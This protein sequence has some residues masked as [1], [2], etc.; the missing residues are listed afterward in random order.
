L[1]LGPALIELSKEFIYPFALIHLVFAFLLL[2]GYS[3]ADQG[4]FE[5]SPFFV[6]DLLSPF[7][8][9]GHFGRPR[10]LG[11]RPTCPQRSL[12]EWTLGRISPV[13]FWL[14]F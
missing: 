13:T 2:F 7:L 12:K 14:P 4:F 5:P 8:W 1:L 6:A 3:V 11:S 10:V 9:P